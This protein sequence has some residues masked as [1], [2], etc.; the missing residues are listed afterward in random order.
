LEHAVLT[1]RSGQLFQLAR[2]DLLAR[3]ARVGLDD[4]Y[5][6]LLDA[7]RRR[8]FASRDQ[9]IQAASQAGPAAHACTWGGGTRT[10]SPSSSSAARA[11]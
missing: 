4:R 6:H 10:P 2:V 1:D 11:A 5:R 3:L 9:G 8:A 7:A